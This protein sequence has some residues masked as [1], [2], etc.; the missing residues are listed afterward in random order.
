[1]KILPS[2]AVSGETPW[3]RLDNAFRQVLTVPKAAIL[4][5]E[6]KEKLDRE[7]KRSTKKPH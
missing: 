1:V 2:P 5:E 7:K 4:K 6:E 3:Q